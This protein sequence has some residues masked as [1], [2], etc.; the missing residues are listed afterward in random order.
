L[1]RQ[2]DIADLLS[3]HR[4]AV[5]R[6]VGALKDESIVEWRGDVFVILALDR[7]ID[8]LKNYPRK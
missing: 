7:L 3:T 5:P 6:E 1:P 2:Q 8:R 4:E